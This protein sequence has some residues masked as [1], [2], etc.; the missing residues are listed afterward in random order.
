[1]TDREYGIAAIGSYD[2]GGA[3]L[4]LT[5]AWYESRGVIGRKFLAHTGIQSRG[6]SF[7]SEAQMASR[8]IASLRRQSDFDPSDCAGVFLSSSSLVPVEQTDWRRDCLKAL[9]RWEDL[10][11]FI[12]P[13]VGLPDGVLRS[14]QWTDELRN[15][16]AIRRLAHKIGISDEQIAAIEEQCLAEFGSIDATTAAVARELAVSPQHVRG[17]N[18]GCSGYV[19]A[20]ELLE[21]ELTERTRPSREQFYLLITVSRTSKFTDFGASDTGALFGDFATATLVTHREN[22]RHPPRLLLRHGST[23]LP[24]TRDLSPDAAL[25]GESLFD[26]ERR[27]NVLT[28]T[29]DGG[30]AHVAERLCWT[31]DGFGVLYAAEPAMAGAVANALGATRIKAA[32]VQWLLGHQPGRKVM[33]RAAGGL[34]GQGYRGQIPLDLMAK[35][36]NI[37]CSSIPHALEMHWEQLDGLVVCPAIGMHAPASPFMS[38]GCLVFEACPVRKPAPLAVA[39]P[40]YAVNPLPT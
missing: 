7:L 26:Y 6:I 8:A 22:P 1:M 14:L 19:R 12:G 40:V 33:E 3:E 20:W 38:Q 13:A 17:V 24:R 30:S 11:R 4:C 39:P 25:L 37:T 23:A 31:M 32:D 35:T 29:P 21:S 10:H 18:W 28:P 5:N 27:T 9:G 15:W 34:R 16:D 36:G 2:P